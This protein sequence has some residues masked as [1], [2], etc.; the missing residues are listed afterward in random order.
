MRERTKLT[1]AVGVGTIAIEVALLLT[2]GFV[3]V[4]GAKLILALEGST[5][6]TE[7]SMMIA[8]LGTGLALLFLVYSKASDYLRSKMCWGLVRHFHGKV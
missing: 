5:G 6:L 8:A 7:K 3:F 1:L 4:E 2:L